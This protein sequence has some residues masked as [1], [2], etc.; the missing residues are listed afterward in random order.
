MKRA[1]KLSAALMFAATIGIGL[2]ASTPATANCVAIFDPGTG[3][4]ADDLFPEC[5]NACTAAGAVI[6]K[7]PGH[8]KLPLRDMNCPM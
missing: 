2:G 3:T 7:V 6:N 4:P 5:F 1:R 8:E